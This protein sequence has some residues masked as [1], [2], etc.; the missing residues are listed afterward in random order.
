V[1][2][3][4]GTLAGALAMIL[5]GNPFS[6]MG[7]APEMLP[8]PTGAIGQLMPPGAGGN[9]LRSTGFF[10]GAAAGGHVAVLLVWAL[11]GLGLLFVAGLRARRVAAAPA[12]APAWHTKTEFL[13]PRPRGAPWRAPLAAFRAPAMTSGVGAAPPGRR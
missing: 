4:A 1:F 13:S 11:G 6:G 7:S 5:I 10:D 2:G 3:Q 12:L 9:L 8:Q